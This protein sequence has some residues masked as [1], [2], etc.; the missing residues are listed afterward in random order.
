MA[1][2]KINGDRLDDIYLKATAN[3]T[4]NYQ[5]PEYYLPDEGKGSGPFIMAYSEI[6][7]FQKGCALLK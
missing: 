1:E 4:D 5:L 7:L 2:L 3:N 6:I